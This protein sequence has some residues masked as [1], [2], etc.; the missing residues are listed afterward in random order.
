MRAT[1]RVLADNK[2]R[3]KQTDF[4]PK[5]TPFGTRYGPLGRSANSGITATVFGSYGFV[6]RYLLS[7]L[8]KILSTPKI[9]PY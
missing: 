3:F 7:E 8:G 2:L 1:R 9:S 6:G 5:A 4:T